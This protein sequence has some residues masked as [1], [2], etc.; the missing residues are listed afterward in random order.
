MTDFSVFV[1]ATYLEK[2]WEDFNRAFV[3]VR[4]KF[5]F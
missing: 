5:I 1:E 3:T 4:E 2:M